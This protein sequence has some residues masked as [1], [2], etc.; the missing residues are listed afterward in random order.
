MRK[1]KEPTVTLVVPGTELKQELTIPHAER[2]LDMGPF[3]N[4]GWEISEDSKYYY[5]EEYGIRIKSDK[6]NSVKTD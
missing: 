1:R 3:L 6:A 5:D 4:G 2:L